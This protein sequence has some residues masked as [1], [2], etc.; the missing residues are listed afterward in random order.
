M[1][2][3]LLARALADGAPIIDDT[4]ATFLWQGPWPPVVAGDLNGWDTR[5]A[6]AVSAWRR[7]APGLWAYQVE[8]PRDAYIEYAFFASTDGGARLPDPLN[9]RATSNGMGADNNFFYMPDA[10]P[11]PLVERQ[12][13]VARGTLSHHTLESGWLLANGRRAVWLYQPPVTQPAPLVVV[14]DGW[15]YLQ[16]GLLAE[17]ADNLIAQG[18]I[19]PIALA[20]ADHGGP[21][22]GV[23]YLCSEATLRFVVDMVVPLAQAQLNLVDIRET[24]GAFGVLGASAGGRMALFTGLMCPEIFGHV[25][26]QS[27]AFGMGDRASVIFSLVR[28]GPVRPLKLWLDCGRYESLLE[29][30]REMHAALTA[31]GYDVVYREYNA[32]HNVP[33]WRNAV[34]RGLEQLFGPHAA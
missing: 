16:R 10:A 11:T 3:P 21:A 25:L 2:H 18:R 1:V 23:E 8:L 5:H 6:P 31:R 14:F 32:G 19:A 28:H 12:A 13:G 7:V 33:A 27:G 9:P 17:I 22:R 30:N 20:F 34:W 15:D 4:T 24:P 26:S 29:P